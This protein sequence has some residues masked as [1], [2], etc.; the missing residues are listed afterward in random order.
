MNQIVDF[1]DLED[2]ENDNLFDCEYSTID[3]V[4]N[5]IVTFTGVRSNVNTDN[6]DRTL[7]AYDNG[8]RK[9]AFFTESKKI[10]AVACDP[11]RVYPFRAIIKVVRYGEFTGFKFFSPKS[12]ITMQDK[13]NFDFYRK[14][15]WRKRQ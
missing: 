7:I 1:E 8:E 14:N 15:K 2:P 10:T 4:I 6:G 5:H 9:S 13:D 3:D 11:K 12:S